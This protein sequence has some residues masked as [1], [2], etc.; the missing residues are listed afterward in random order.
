MNYHVPSEKPI[1][2]SEPEIYTTL[3]GN[4]MSRRLLY[5]TNPPMT[6]ATLN[7]L[8]ALL[9]KTSIASSNA[10]SVMLDRI[11]NEL[12]SLPASLAYNFTDGLRKAAMLF[13]LSVWIVPETN[14]D[15]NAMSVI[16]KGTDPPEECRKK[17][18][19]AFE[20]ILKG[21]G[22]S[23]E[24]IEKWL[25]TCGNT[26]SADIHKTS[27]FV[28][29]KAAA[30]AAAE[31]RGFTNTDTEGAWDIISKFYV[32]IENLLKLFVPEKLNPVH[33]KTNSTIDCQ[34]LLVKRF[35]T[36]QCADFKN[37]SE[38]YFNIAGWAGYW[39]DVL[40]GK[41]GH[42][43]LLDGTPSICGLFAHLSLFINRQKNYCIIKSNAVCSPLANPTRMNTP[44]TRPNGTKSEGW[45]PRV[46]GGIAKPADAKT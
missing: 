5:G 8:N 7:E 23:P 9:F 21:E 31:K 19:D 6:E 45:P 1:L 4:M 20:S 38:I 42:L 28:N 30:A 10:A 12:P 13:L 27:S 36:G 43:E 39:A 15:S 40:Q 29:R 32:N 25:E 16:A 14:T 24:Q 44:P 18:R 26:L 22:L 17:M 2:K 35:G 34:L 41:K 11:L 37:L 46:P 3:K 33:H